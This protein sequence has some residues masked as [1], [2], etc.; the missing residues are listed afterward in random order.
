MIERNGGILFK[1]DRGRQR[2]F[3]FKYRMEGLDCT[4]TVDAACFS[5]AC[6][7]LGMMHGARFERSSV[8]TDYFLDLSEPQEG[9]PI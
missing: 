8:P 1:S 5:E 2:R 9:V 6:F 7:L 4:E 3:T